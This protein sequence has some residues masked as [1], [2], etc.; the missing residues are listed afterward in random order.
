LKDNLGSRYFV[1]EKETKVLLDQR[2]SSIL[3]HG[4]KPVGEKVYRDLLPLVCEVSGVSEVDLPQFPV[5]PV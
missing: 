4:D 1:R 2:N 3:A 5:L